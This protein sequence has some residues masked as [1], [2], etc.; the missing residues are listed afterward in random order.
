MSPHDPNFPD[1]VA[2]TEQDAVSTQFSPDTGRRLKTGAGIAAAVLLLGFIIVGVIRFF[3]GRA[4]GLA[5]EKAYL[6]PPPVAVV[7][8]RPASAGPDRVLP[9]QT[10]AS[11]DATIYARVACSAAQGPVDLRDHGSN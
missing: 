3:D 7:I 8:A 4:L 10:A 11:D 1:H 9:R 6:A 2:G 5:E